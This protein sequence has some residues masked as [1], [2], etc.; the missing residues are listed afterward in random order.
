MLFSLFFI[1]NS[2]RRG[3]VFKYSMVRIDILQILYI[4]Y[5]TNHTPII[6]SIHSFVNLNSV[7]ISYPQIL[8]WL[9][10]PIFFITRLRSIYSNYILLLYYIFFI[11]YIYVYL[12]GISITSEFLVIK[13]SLSVYIILLLLI[14]KKKTLLKPT[15]F[16]IW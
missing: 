1:H 11:K 16:Y 3:R 9:T 12:L 10:I 8:L 15:L 13:Y 6:N 14:G 4:I 2:F 7:S 5:F